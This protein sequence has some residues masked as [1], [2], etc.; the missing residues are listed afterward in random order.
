MNHSILTFQQYATMKKL[1]VKTV[2]NR[3]K[4]NTLNEQVLVIGKQP[5]I[6]IYKK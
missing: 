1:A 3:Y 4:K 5:H 6:I 2:Y